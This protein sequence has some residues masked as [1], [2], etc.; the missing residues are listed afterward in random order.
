MFY[1]MTKGLGFC[2][3]LRPPRPEA[4]TETGFSSSLWPPIH[5]C[6]FQLDLAWPYFTFIFLQDC[7][8]C[9]IQAPVA[10]AKKIALEEYLTSSPHFIWPNPWNKCVCVYVYPGDTASLIELWLIQEP[11]TLLVWEH[12]SRK[13]WYL[14]P[15]DAPIQYVEWFSMG[16]QLSRQVFKALELTFMLCTSAKLDCW[17]LSDQTA[18]FTYPKCNVLGGRPSLTTT[19]WK[20]GQSFSVS[21]GYLICMEVCVVPLGNPPPLSASFWKTWDLVYNCW[22]F[23]FSKKDSRHWDCLNYYFC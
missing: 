3:A 4:T 13:L 16:P 21:H 17:Q 5:A 9:G 2:R 6:G 19:R 18:I 11:K 22:G 10:D 23:F 15:H 7:L 12:G 14:W 20:T 1:P 8:T